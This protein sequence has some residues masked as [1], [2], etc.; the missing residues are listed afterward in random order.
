MIRR[1]IRIL[2]FPIWVGLLASTLV[3]IWNPPTIAQ[4]IPDL[5]WSEDSISPD[6]YIPIF[7]VGNLE[8]SW[9]RVNYA[10]EVS[11]DADLDRVMEVIEEVAQQLYRDPQW[12][13]Q[14]LEAPEIL[15]IDNISHTGILIRLIIKTQ[16]LEQWSVAREF[17]R[18]LKKALD[19]QGIKVGIPQQMMYFSDN[20]AK[21]KIFRENN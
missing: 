6:S 19:E 17:R 1:T 20:F 5:N 3:L 13:E 21:S 8:T 9:S 11:Y 18:R 14:I 16:P 12:Q 2:V 15:G 7:T 4:V 10:I